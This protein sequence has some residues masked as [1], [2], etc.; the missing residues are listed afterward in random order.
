[1]DPGQT[2]SSLICRA[3]GQVHFLQKTGKSLPWSNK[4]VSKLFPHTFL[5][6]CSLFS[7]ISHSWTSESCSIG[8]CQTFDYF[9][10]SSWS[11]R[12]FTVDHSAPGVVCGSRDVS[13]CSYL[14]RCPPGRHF[15]FLHRDGV[16]WYCYFALNFPELIHHLDSCPTWGNYSRK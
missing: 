7:L 14:E 2:T 6:I 1:M 3:G 10:Q 16:D 11:P 5:L 12:S 13:W 4:N 15:L 8:I 9:R